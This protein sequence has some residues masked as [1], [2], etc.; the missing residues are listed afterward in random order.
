[1]TMRVLMVCAALVCCTCE[2][3]WTRLMPSALGDARLGRSLVTNAN[4]ITLITG[5]RMTTCEAHS[6]TFTGW[7][8]FEHSTFGTNIVLFPMINYTPGPV[9]MVNPDLLNNAGGHTNGGF[10]LDGVRVF[11][12]IVLSAYPDAAVSNTWPNGVYT[13]DGESEQSVTVSV[14]GNE[15]N[16]GPGAW[17]RNVIAGPSED[18]TVSGAG[19]V[20][21]GVSKTPC[22][23][24][25]QAS[26][27]S[28][29]LG[30]GTGSEVFS[31]MA[32]SITNDVF[33]FWSVRLDLNDSNH[34][35]S[36]RNIQRNGSVTEFTATNTLPVMGERIFT[37][38]GIYQLLVTGAINSTNKLDRYFDLRVNC[39]WLSDD[40]LD[41]IWMNGLE[42]LQRRGL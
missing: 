11:T 21:I 15:V 35:Y 37:D 31:V 12:N 14:G 26:G 33:T 24:F 4:A 16:L 19:D 10:V 9:S 17:T 39:G 2:A 7:Y 27:A 13:V 6:L 3:Q 5:F 42:E 34:V 18:I 8:K 32:C 30:D 23:E 40:E 22:H 28:G 41:R 36:C 1:M 20:R 25:F 38:R 29:T